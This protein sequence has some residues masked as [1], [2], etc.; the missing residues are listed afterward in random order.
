MEESSLQRWFPP[1]PF[2]GAAAPSSEQL[3]ALGAIS[4]SWTRAEI[5]LFDIY[6]TLRRRAREKVN[7]MSARNHNDELMRR[8]KSLSSIHGLIDTELRNL[9]TE[10][11][12]WFDAVRAGRNEAIHE[13]SVSPWSQAFVTVR[14]SEGGVRHIVRDQI[15][16]DELR[17]LALEAFDMST[18][19]N[20]LEVQV[21]SS[22]NRCGADM[23]HWMRFG[24]RKKNEP[25]NEW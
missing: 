5:A 14:K 16:L 9:L 8:V 15:N 2:K 11:V 23:R 6:V 13:L 19:L 18:F 24:P 10:G 12:D 17:G 3:E 22:P 25:R 20:W 7:T 4:V 21:L 1:R